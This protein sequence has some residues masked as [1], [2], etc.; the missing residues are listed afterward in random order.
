[1]NSELMLTILITLLIGNAAIIKNGMRIKS[2]IPALRPYPPYGRLNERP[3]PAVG[4]APVF[5]IH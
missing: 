1:M 3:R 2:P 5:K 4:Q